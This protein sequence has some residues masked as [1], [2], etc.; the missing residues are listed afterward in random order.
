MA[1]HIQLRAGQG[2]QGDVP[3]EA[4]A[5]T[6]S[7]LTRSAET[8]LGGLPLPQHKA[9]KRSCYSF[10]TLHSFTAKKRS[11]VQWHS[12][13]KII[14]SRRECVGQETNLPHH[15]TE[16]RSESLPIPSKT[17]KPK[18]QSEYVWERKHFLSTNL[19][20]RISADRT[21]PWSFYLAGKSF[22]YANLAWPSPC[23]IALWRWQR[24]ADH[25]YALGSTKGQTVQ[26]SVINLCSSAFLPQLL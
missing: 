23:L 3:G 8:G 4:C 18:D 2:S 24:Q 7:S 14:C 16:A 17:P 21:L 10:S 5:P 6:L 11:T 20:C 1:E 26:A 19:Q 22:P 9:A 15:P 25:S 13:P 12:L